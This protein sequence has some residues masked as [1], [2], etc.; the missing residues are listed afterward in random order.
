MHEILELIKELWSGC[1][2]C[3]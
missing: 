1:V 3:W 2:Q